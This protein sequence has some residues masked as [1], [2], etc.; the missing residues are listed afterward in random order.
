MC[1]GWRKDLG[2][3]RSG[4]CGA[5]WRSPGITDPIGCSIQRAAIFR[6]AMIMIR[7][8]LAPLALAALAAIVRGA[9]PIPPPRPKAAP[10]S[11]SNNA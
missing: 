3:R 1:V 4:V 10:S 2:S 11:R 7:A 8:A 6:R 9:S 5:I